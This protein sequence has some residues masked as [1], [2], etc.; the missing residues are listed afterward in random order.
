[1]EYESRTDVREPESRVSA[2]LITP[3]GNL[4]NLLCKQRFTPAVYGVPKSEDL[5]RSGLQLPGL[6]QARRSDTL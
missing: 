3:Q 6:A 5:A 4:A 2:A 1:M